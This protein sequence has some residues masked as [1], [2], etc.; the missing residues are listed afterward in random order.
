V[1]E[2]SDIR[3]LAQP[4]MSFTSSDRHARFGSN[5]EE[6]SANKCFPHCP[7]TRRSRDDV[8]TSLFCAMIGLMHRGKD[9]HGLRTTP[10]R[11][12]RRGNHAV[13]NCDARTSVS[14]LG[15]AGAWCR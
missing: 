13:D 15:E 2:P 7:R 3:E 6:F 8:G 5:S 12:L 4:R 10:M 9:G 11:W 1:C 14:K